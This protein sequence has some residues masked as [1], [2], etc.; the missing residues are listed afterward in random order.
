MK[1]LKS[2]GLMALILLT[3]VSIPEKETVCVYGNVI[4]ASETAITSQLA[5]PRRSTTRA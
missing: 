3:G 4:D 2:I 1:T 5:K